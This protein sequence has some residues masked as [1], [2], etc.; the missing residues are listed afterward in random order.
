MTRARRRARA[1]LLSLRATLAVLG[2]DNGPQ[3]GRG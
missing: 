2:M 1:A 3:S